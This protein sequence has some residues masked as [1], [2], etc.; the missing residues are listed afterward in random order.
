M[1]YFALLG[2]FKKCLDF[3]KCI[4]LSINKIEINWIK[5]VVCVKCN[6][7]AKVL[8]ASP[9]PANWLLTQ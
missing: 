6:E 1:K 5:V 2:I 9:A 7:S 4:T 8:K 3:E